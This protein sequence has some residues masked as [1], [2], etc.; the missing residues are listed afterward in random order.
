MASV[1]DLE[2]DAV[3]IGPAS[4]LLLLEADAKGEVGYRLGSRAPEYLRFGDGFGGLRLGIIDN[5]RTI[6]V[7]NPL[8]N[9]LLAIGAHPSGHLRCFFLGAEWGVWFD[10][11]G[12]RRTNDE[13]LEMMEDLRFS[14]AIDF[15]AREVTFDF[16]LNIYNREA[17]TAD[18]RR[19]F[20]E[21]AFRNLLSITFKVPSG[22]YVRGEV[23]HLDIS[24]GVRHSAYMLKEF[25]L[26]W[27]VPSEG[28]L[29][30]GVFQQHR[31][32]QPEPPRPEPVRPPEQADAPFRAKLKPRAAAP[33]PP[34]PPPPRQEEVPRAKLGA[35]PP[36]PE[37]PPVSDRPERARM[38]PPPP[39]ERPAAPAEAEEEPLVRTEQFTTGEMV[40]A[41]SRERVA[42][43]RWKMIEANLMLGRPERTYAL[44][45]NFADLL[46]E[47]TPAWPPARL[48]MVFRDQPGSVLI[49]VMG[50]WY[51]HQILAVSE[52]NPESEKIMQ[53]L[54]ERE[55]ERLLRLSIDQRPAN[56][57]A[58][59]R[60][61]HIDRTADEQAIKRVWR[62]LLGFM[63]ADL[64]RQ[65]ERAIHRKKDEIAKHLQAARDLIIKN[66]A[67]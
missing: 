44:I 27:T 33:P 38:R 20:R 18:T 36:R 9:R 19:L 60:D 56:I 62:T 53:W 16:H 11:A 64:G 31:P 22:E 29:S 17:F 15:G 67:R 14:I 43:R 37:R 12:R 2:T 10:E 5:L 13:P 50:S 8:N 61:L 4:Y 51:V 55:V 42:D 46:L 39:P 41:I 1:P 28:G 35:A 52:D 21:G 58:A 6:L 23:T 25:P 7:I 63:N 26:V 40:R 59:R 65:E 54:R 34:P 48:R 32:P 30:D 49:G 3:Q 45:A 66:R 24:T 47:R 57:D